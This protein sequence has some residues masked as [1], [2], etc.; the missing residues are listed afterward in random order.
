[1]VALRHE[2]NFAELKK[3][4]E[5]L[6]VKR[7]VTRW[8]STYIMVQRCIRIRP[9]IKK[10]ETVEALIPTGGKHRK[11]IALSE[12]L[13][14]FESICKRLQREDTYMSDVRM[15][16]VAL[17]KAYPVMAEHLK[18]NAKI[19]HTPAFESRIVHKISSCELSTAEEAALKRF[20]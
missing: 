19:V 14:K 16:F 15:M 9:E 20:E 1:M 18:A 17:V 5:L 11:F 12:H 7:T 4:T 13:K 3:N 6:P 10:V 2:N 8:A